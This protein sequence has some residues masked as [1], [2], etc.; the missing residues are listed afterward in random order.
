[1]TRAPLRREV[2]GATWV[3]VALAVSGCTG[4]ATGP[5][6]GGGGEAGITWEEACPM[7]AD[8]PI[9]LAATRVDADG[10]ELTWG[11]G[12]VV[13]AFHGRLYRSVDGG[14]WDLVTDVEL[15]NGAAARWVDDDAPSGDVR[16]RLR[17]VLDCGAVGLVEGDPVEAGYV[18]D[19][20]VATMT[21][22]EGWVSPA[23]TVAEFCADVAPR[24][25]SAQVTDHGVVVTWLDGTEP[26]R[27]GTYW[28]SLHRRPA[29]ATEWEVFDGEHVTPEERA[30]DQP[31]P[32][33][34][35]VDEDPPD[36]MPEYGISIDVH[37]CWPESVVTA[38]VPTR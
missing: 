37:V 34:S 30:I 25:A 32:Q 5:G 7:M 28:Y 24:E 31:G 21:A 20:A 2:A 19:D 23:R 38:G 17:S 8:D 6:G 9:G 3:A 15:P 26:P 29:G 11:E 16:Y 36:P 14:P 1:M 12:Y 22:P 35:F 18:G 27:E 13:S 33:R 4:P 10:V